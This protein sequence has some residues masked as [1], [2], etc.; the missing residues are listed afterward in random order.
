MRIENKAEEYLEGI[1]TSLQHCQ[2]QIETIRTS[3]SSTSVELTHDRIQTSP[4][5]NRMLDGVADILDF[6]SEVSR[7]TEEAFDFITQLECENKQKVL[8]LLY[9]EN[10]KVVEI[11]SMMNY[12]RQHVY[13]ILHEATVQLSE[14]L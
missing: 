11:A 9:I 6:E 14:Y 4:N 13:R 7:M 10:N 12:T 8:I 1:R 2:E 5:V 3:L